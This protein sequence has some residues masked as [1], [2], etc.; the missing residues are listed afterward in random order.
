MTDEV[1]SDSV[2]K[3]FVSWR[4]DHDKFVA[5]TVGRT[6]GPTTGTVPP[7][8]RENLRLRFDVR[9]RDASNTP[10]SGRTT[11]THTTYQVGSG[12]TEVECRAKANI[13][14]R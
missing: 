3:A 10:S 7:R 6:A 11:E 13:N 12:A 5:G 2:R 1:L 4:D 14:S 9:D 8:A